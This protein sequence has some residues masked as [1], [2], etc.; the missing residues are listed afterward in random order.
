MKKIIKLFLFAFVLFGL[1]FVKA[2]AAVYKVNVALKNINP[3]DDSKEYT[4]S[5]QGSGATKNLSY[6][7]LEPKGFKETVKSGDWIYTF[8]GWYTEDGTAISDSYHY[9]DLDVTVT[10]NP[11]D[12]KIKVAR[13]TAGADGEDYLNIYAHWTKKSSVCNVTITFQEQSSTGATVNSGNGVSVSET[14]KLTIGSS[15]TND[16]SVELAKLKFSEGGYVYE[17]DGWYYNGSKVSE[18]L[19][20]DGNPYRINPTFACTENS[21]GV[22]EFVYT[23]KWTEYKAPVIIFK[24]I[25]E[26]NN[27]NGTGSWSNENGGPNEYTHT[28]TEPTGTDDYKFLYWKVG[29]KE[30]KGGDSY[31]ISS[32]GMAYGETKEETAYAWWQPGIK[33]NYYNEDKSAY[34][35]QDEWSFE[36]VQMINDYPTKPGYDFAG[37][38]DENGNKVDVDT[39]TKP[40]ITTEPGKAVTIKLYASYTRIMVDLKLNK[41]WVDFKPEYRKS[42]TFEVYKD[43]GNTLVGT[44][45]LSAEEVSETADNVWTKTV[46]LP[47][48]EEDGTYIEYTVKEI[49]VEYYTSESESNDDND[50]ITVT[51]TIENGTVVVNHVDEEDGTVLKSETIEKGIGDSYTT[52]DTTIENYEYT[53]EYDG[54]TSGFVTPEETVVTYYYRALIGTITVY[55][56]DIDTM[57]TMETATFSGKYTVEWPNIYK[58]FEDYEF[59]ESDKEM[60]GVFG[61]GVTEITLFYT[62]NTGDEGGK[63]DDDIITPPHTDADILIIEQTLYLD[64]RKYKKNKDF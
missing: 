44:Y 28:F 30:L 38:V 50:E 55:Y 21:T 18:S 1:G 17:I 57:E 33:V 64:D 27:N 4:F 24:Y 48:Y 42:V 3:T 25:N 8:D 46:S 23:L 53:G 47:R 2:D 37:W 39:F 52:S 40:D 61:D 15:W 14:Q 22:H 16:K 59:V 6:T 51:N 60:T 58:D 13:G 12:R 11:T 9:T 31:T 43:N 49:S 5:L 26:I 32:D 34:K 7:Q 56:V 35:L 63:D 54:E 45:T 20:V 29:D 36:D 10:P 62:K 19:Y 41:V